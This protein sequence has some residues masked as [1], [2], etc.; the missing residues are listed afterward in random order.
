MWRVVNHIFQYFPV[1][2]AGAFCQ[3]WSRYY[4]VN[5]VDSR[6]QFF[7]IRMITAARP[8]NTR[9]NILTSQTWDIHELGIFQD[10]WH[11]SD[12][13][14][15]SIYCQTLFRVLSAGVLCTLQIAGWKPT[16]IHIKL[17][18]G[19]FNLHRE[20]LS[21]HR[22]HPVNIPIRIKKKQRMCGQSPHHSTTRTLT[23][24]FSLNCAL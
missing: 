2:D 7:T 10:T 4:S 23:S 18:V 21:L 19:F 6:K 3:P 16:S 1:N 9:H 11:T 22:G 24:T 15:F 8:A 12:W 17:T 13:I 5:W 20:W 14:S